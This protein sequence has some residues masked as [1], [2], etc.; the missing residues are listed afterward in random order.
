MQVMKNCEKFLRDNK[1]A[2][3]WG[4]VWEI[5]NIMKMFVYNKYYK[6]EEVLRIR[7]LIV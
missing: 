4:K 1:S 3:C 6:Q 2:N 7:G 5:K